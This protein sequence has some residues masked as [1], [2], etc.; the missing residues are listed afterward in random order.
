MKYCDFSDLKVTL[1]ALYTFSDPSVYQTLYA[2]VENQFKDQNHLRFIREDR[3]LDQIKALISFE[4]DYFSFM[5]DDMIFFREVDL[6]RAVKVLQANQDCL[7]V[8]LKLSPGLYYSHTNDKC[9]KLPKTFQIV[10]DSFF[11]YKRDDTELDWNYPFDFCGSIY[12]RTT[13]SDE[14]VPRI[15]DQQKMLKPN[16]FEFAGN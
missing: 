5:V 11:K 2:Q 9:I 3:T 12:L 1:S 16:T 8:H 4:A 13:V 6:S 10:D 7:A 15:L 14:I